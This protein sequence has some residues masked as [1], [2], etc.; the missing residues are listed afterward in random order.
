MTCAVAEVATRQRSAVRR[1]ASAHTNVPVA[2][3]PTSDIGELLGALII[4]IGMNRGAL[5]VK[6]PMDRL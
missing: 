1:V 4:V 5:G 2:K 6:S 3:H